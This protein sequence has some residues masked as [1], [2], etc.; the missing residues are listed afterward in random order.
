M[1]H[2]VSSIMD[3]ATLGLASSMM[4]KTPDIPAPATPAAVPQSQAAKTP[5]AD[6]VQGQM[7]GAGQAGGSPG[8]A[9]T[10][11]TGPSGVDPASLN[12]GRNSLLGS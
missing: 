10:M 1:G 4:P 8:V 5:T 7:A 9:Q 6:T 11:L 12:L 2:V 3:V